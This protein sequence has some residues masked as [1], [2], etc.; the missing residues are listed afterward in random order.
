[1]PR[2]IVTIGGVRVIDMEVKEGKYVVS[3]GTEVAAGKTVHLPGVAYP[4]PQPS[5]TTAS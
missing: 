1:M 2:T 4:K 5:P 3:N